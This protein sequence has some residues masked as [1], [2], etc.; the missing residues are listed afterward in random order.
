[1][2]PIVGAIQDTVYLLEQIN[3]SPAAQHADIDIALPFSQ[4]MS[5]RNAK[6]NLLSVGKATCTPLQFYFMAILTFHP[7]HNSFHSG[8]DHL[9]LPQNIVL[10]HHI[11][12]IMLTG[13][14]KQKT[15][16]TLDRLTKH[17]ASEDGRYIQP[18]S[19]SVQSP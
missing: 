9:S 4:Y 13:Q 19:K 17:I 11:D 12:D 8:L 14:S 7:G 3:T 6:T 2:T 18:K 1:M 10:V 16:T 15:A 5:K